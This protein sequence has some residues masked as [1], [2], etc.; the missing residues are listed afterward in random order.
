MT[1]LAESHSHTAAVCRGEAE[2]RRSTDPVFA[3]LLDRWAANAE[4]RADEAH[5][6]TQPD[7]F[8]TAA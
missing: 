2:A 8:R 5:A 4:R 1:R 6:K 3:G 7:F